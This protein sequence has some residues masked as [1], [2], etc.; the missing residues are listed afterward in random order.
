MDTLD[1]TGKVAVVTGASRGIGRVLTL[2]LAKRGA[3]VVGTAREMDSSPGTGGTLRET[4]E[5]VEAAG[6]KGLAVPCRITEEAEAQRLIDQ[7]HRAFGRIDILVN[8]A[9]T[10]PHKAL[11]EMTLDE[12]NELLDVNLTAPFLL[13]RAVLP[14]MKQQRSGHILNLSSGAGI[15]RPRPDVTAYSATKAAIDRIT[16]NLAHEMREHGI[17]V[18]SLMPGILLT[19][20]NAGRGVGDPVEI[21]EE[22]GLWILAQAPSNFTGQIVRREDYGETWGPG[23]AVNAG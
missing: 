23:A 8:N 6:G 17:A 14:T 5:M 11:A 18:N 21:V 2:G 15:A 3:A 22:P 7:A 9:G 13:T 16:H 10:H 20:M 1:F 19:D 12:W 4:F